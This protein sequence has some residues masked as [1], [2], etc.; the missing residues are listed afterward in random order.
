MEETFLCQHSVTAFLFQPVIFF[1]EI[2]YCILWGHHFH[3]KIDRLICLKQN[4][5][6][7]TDF[8]NIN[9]HVSIL[10]YLCTCIWID[11]FLTNRSNEVSLVMVSREHHRL[12]LVLKNLR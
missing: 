5:V 3:R 7:R 8:I 10:T 4:K 6:W 11:T 2:L 9:V 1:F 12:T